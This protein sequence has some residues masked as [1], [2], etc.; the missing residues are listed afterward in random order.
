M[1]LTNQ[2]IQSLDDGHPVAVTVQGREVVVLPRDA[3]ER[4]RAL[5]DFDPAQAYPAIDEA[6]REGWD[7]SKMAD[8]DRYEEFRS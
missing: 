2:H 7:D 6:W 8:Y 3:Y 5:L 4:V 1:N